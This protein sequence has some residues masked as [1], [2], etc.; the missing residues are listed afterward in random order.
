MSRSAKNT[1]REKSN[2]KY[3]EASNIAYINHRFMGE[4]YIL[5]IQKQHLQCIKTFLTLL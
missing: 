3:E 1:D 5:T 4:V 2:V